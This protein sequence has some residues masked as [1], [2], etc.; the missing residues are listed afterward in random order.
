M[1]SKHSDTRPAGEHARGYRTH[2]DLLPRD[3]CPALM[4]KQILV[5]GLDDRIWDDGRSHPGDGYS[6]CQKTCTQ[7]GPDDEI[8][9]ADQCRPGRACWHGL[10]L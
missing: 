8:V 5:H 6:W 10:E 4:M 1:E 2:R 3:V 9:G 7:V